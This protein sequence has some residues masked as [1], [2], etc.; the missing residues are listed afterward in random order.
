MNEERREGSGRVALQGSR[1]ASVS[2]TGEL[3]WGSSPHRVRDGVQR[4]VRDSGCANWRC[5]GK[6]KVR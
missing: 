3:C 5:V 1:T 2:L 6:V 4:L